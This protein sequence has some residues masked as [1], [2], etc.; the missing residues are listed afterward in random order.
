MYTDAELL[1]IAERVER[2]YA[3]DM[4]IR[5]GGALRPCTN[6]EMFASLRRS[7][8]QVRSWCKKFVQWVADGCPLPR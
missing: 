8:D 4:M 7:K 3:G 5:D 2:D 6:V 1:D